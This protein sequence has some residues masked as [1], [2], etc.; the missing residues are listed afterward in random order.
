MGFTNICAPVI[1]FIGFSLIQIIIDLYSGVFDSAF[2]K[3]IVMVIIALVIN[4]LCDL[5]LTVIAWFFVFIPII[6]MTIISTLLL[7]VFGTNPD[8]SELQ[9]QVVDVSDNTFDTT[10]TTDTTDIYDYAIDYG[11]I[12]RDEIRKDL[13]KTVLEDYYDVSAIYTP[14]N[15][16]LVDSLLNSYGESYFSDNITKFYNYVMY[17]ATYY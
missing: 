17:P 3:I 13:Y 11:R 6:M 1:I 5:G 8:Q 7:M 12:D 14:Q 16:A 10:Y 9:S 2:T 4:I 15:Y